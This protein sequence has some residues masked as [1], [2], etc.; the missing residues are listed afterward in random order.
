MVTTFNSSRH[1]CRYAFAD[2]LANKWN[3][4]YDLVVMEFDG[5]RMGMFSATITTKMKS[6]LLA[7]AQKLKTLYAV[8]SEIPGLGDSSN[9]ALWTILASVSALGILALVLFILK[10][11]FAR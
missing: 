5:I 11:K 9:S 1:S 10:R 7:A 4:E 8:W 3:K 6:N 2:V